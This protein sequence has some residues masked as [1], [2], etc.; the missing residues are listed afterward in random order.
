MDPLFVVVIVA[1]TAAAM[2][3]LAGNEFSRARRGA[4]PSRQLPRAPAPIKRDPWAGIGQ[5]QAEYVGRVLTVRVW[6]TPAGRVSMEWLVDPKLG[7][8]SRVIAE[9]EDHVFSVGHG[10]RGFCD[11]ILASGRPMHYRF[12]ACDERGEM[13]PDVSFVL[14][15]SNNREEGTTAGL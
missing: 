14:Q 7:R 15:R 5:F 13:K 8:S 2:L 3:R 12:S 1:W 4:A 6:T 10:A 9:D 11:H